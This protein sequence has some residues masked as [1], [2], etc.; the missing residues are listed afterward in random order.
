ML[1]VITKVQEPMVIE[2]GGTELTELIPMLERELFEV[3][4]ETSILKRELEP[5]LEDTATRVRRVDLTRRQLAEAED[6]YIAARENA[7]LRSGE[8]DNL[9]VA[10]QSL[11]EEM[12]RLLAD[13]RPQP[14]D[15]TVAG[16]AVD[17]EYI[18]FVIDT[19]GSMRVAAWRAVLRTVSDSLE[20][21]PKGIRGIQVMNAD[22]NYLLS[23]YAGRWIPYSP[24]SRRSIISALGR[25]QDY[26]LSSPAQGIVRAISTFS[27]KSSKISIFVFG[28]DFQGGSAEAL[29][30]YV[31]RINKADRFG[32]RLVRI[33]AVGFPAPGSIDPGG[34]ANLMRVL[35]NRNGGTFVARRDL[36]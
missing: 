8:A 21:Y 33:N 26:S 14:T 2:S 25:W 32:N 4:S 28:D 34:F 23:A 35:C 24:A 15:T 6:R 12:K 5:L 7:A 1:L 10:R 13:Y 30:R 18:I 17:S 11:T 36:D 9:L 31:E 22:G 19:S 20:V 16:V 29:V 27:E 3:R